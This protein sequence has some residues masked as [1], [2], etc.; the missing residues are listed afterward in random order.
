[1]T[2]PFFSDDQMP[3]HDAATVILLRKNGDETRVLM[4]Q[5]GKSA[6]F[7]PGKF[8]FPGGRVDPQDY[9]VTAPDMVNPVCRARLEAAATPELAAALLVAARRELLEETGLN[10]GPLASL[11]FI[12]RAITPP[13]RPR[14]FDARFLMCDAGDVLDDLDDFSRA[15]DELAHLQ[16]VSVAEALTLD[17][18]FVTRV[19]LAEV[20][21]LA[22]T[23]VSPEV[24]PFY[25]HSGPIGRIIS[26]G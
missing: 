19:V 22:S 18:P 24:V 8:V 20:N 15:E 4:G 9:E 11:R 12:F 13:K 21:A 2:Q 25:E 10:L 26:L 23:S 17:L 7:M 16:W 14:R 6:V 3:I 1:M 5:R